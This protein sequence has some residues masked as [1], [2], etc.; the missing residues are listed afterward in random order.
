M[1]NRWESGLLGRIR[2]LSRGCRSVG[3]V[4]KN[5]QSLMIAGVLATPQRAEIRTG[6]MIVA[7]QW[8]CTVHQTLAMILG[9]LKA[10][11]W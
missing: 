9:R 6:P 1:D 10:T 3:Q 8:N 4:R 11:S 7:C 5:S 2:R